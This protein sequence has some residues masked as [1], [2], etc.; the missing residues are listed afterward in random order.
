MN[1]QK[2]IE[3]AIEEFKAKM[4][5]ISS[6]SEGAYFAFA[7]TENDEHGLT[8]G[9]R[10]DLSGMML[11]NTLANLV[12]RTPGLDEKYIDTVYNVTKQI[13]RDLQEGYGDMQ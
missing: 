4:R 5:K 11:S 9:G 10:V 8:F 7:V 3:N 12:Y 13:Y 1:K 2:E 6:G